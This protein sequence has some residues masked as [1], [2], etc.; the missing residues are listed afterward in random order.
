[1]EK[2]T[3]VTNGITHRRW[4]EQANPRLAKFINDL[5]GDRWLKDADYL[6]ELQKFM[7]DKQALERLEKI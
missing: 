4:V 7:G 2:F 5:I 1:P 3:N 6:Q